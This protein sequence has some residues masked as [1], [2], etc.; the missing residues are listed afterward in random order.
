MHL[1]KTRIASG[2]FMSA[3]IDDLA[4]AANHAM[5]PLCVDLDGTLTYSD[6]LVESVIQISSPW[7]LLKC[8]FTL[9]VNGK[10]AFKS[11]VGKFVSIDPHQLPYNDALLTHIRN[12]RGLGRRTVLITAANEKI[13]QAV[14][15]HLGCFDEVHSSSSR[16]NLKGKSKA[17]LLQRLFGRKGFSYAGND[18]SDVDV[19]RVSAGAIIVNAPKGVVAK[20]LA[21]APVER[22]FP[23]ET[24]TSWLLLKAMRPYQWVKNL[25]VFVPIITAHAMTDTLSWLNAFIAFSA[26]SATASG[27]YLINDA[28]DIHADRAH[29]RKK[30]RPFASG[31][32]SINH[33][34]VASAI[35][36]CT[37]L[38]L[39]NSCGILAIV[40]L[41]GTMSF[42]Y[43]LKFKEFPLVDVFALAALYTVRLF[44]GGVASGH[45]LSLWLLGFSGFIFLGLALLKRVAELSDLVIKGTGGLARRGYS[46]DDLDILKAMGGASSFSATLLLALFVQAETTTHTY[47]SPFALWAMVPLVLFWQCR[48]WLATSRGYMTDDPIVYSIKDWVS[49]IVV[50]LLFLILLA[51]YYIKF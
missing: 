37:G 32:L 19:W 34:L 23:R 2:A 7:L 17:E 44:G 27:I 43:S 6:T 20:G 25:L 49:W 30:M 13:A 18:R 51:A 39:A 9:L 21:V 36:I 41:Y 10:A 42:S 15:E 1:S 47:S 3:G 22:I 35:L 31:T 50:G 24:S 26:F 28:T 38:C 16:L 5:T 14:A 46:T 45:P 33:G 11:E 4:A 40:V 8:L 12:Q 29:P 48:L